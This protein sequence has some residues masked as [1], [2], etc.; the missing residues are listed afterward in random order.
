MKRESGACETR[1]KAFLDLSLSLINLAEKGR[2]II[3]YYRDISRMILEFSG[4]DSLN[5]IAGDLSGYSRFNFSYSKGWI[6]QPLTNFPSPSDATLN[7]PEGNKDLPKGLTLEALEEAVY[8]GTVKGSFPAAEG[9]LYFLDTLSSGIVTD[10]S[11]LLILPVKTQNEIIGSLSLGW[12]NPTRLEM[13]ELELYQYLADL[14]GFAKLHRRAQFLLSER[15]KELRTIYQ[16]SRL[17]SDIELSLDDLLEKAA[18]IIPPG[19]LYPQSA[20]CKI[21]Y[22]S[23]VFTSKDYQTPIYTLKEDILVGHEVRGYVEVGY[24]LDSENIDKEPFLKEEQPMLRAIAGELGHVAGRKQFEDERERLQQ[25]LLHSDRLA[26]VGQLTAGVAHELN[27]PLGGI[28]GFA[29]LIKKYG[30]I[31]ESVE[32]DIDKIIKAS[33]HGREIIRKLMLFSRQTPPEKKMVSIND[34]IEDGLFLLESRVKKS[35]IILIKEF[36]DDL[37]PVKIDPS[38][39]NQVL[40]NLV[41]NAIQAMPDGGILTI[42][43]E[44]SIDAILLIVEDTGVGMN[45]EQLN[46]IFIPFYTTKGINEGVGLGLPVALGIVQS[47][48]GSISVQ[49]EPGQGTVFTVKF[50]TGGEDNG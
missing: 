32:K 48:R 40:V 50:P 30:D 10:Y 4:A 18:G 43:T 20:C 7:L 38:Q 39:L 21:V 19:F 1:F 9:G 25:Q 23:K 8:S 29:Q 42:K 6:V 47:H 13:E 14:T 34:R 12:K 35:D 45:E 36:A 17:G 5:I 44:S 27:E 2:N 49:S 3:D 31:N 46:R 11:S 15:I 41:V 16:I 24:T 33:L 37:P 26:T 28:L 22:A